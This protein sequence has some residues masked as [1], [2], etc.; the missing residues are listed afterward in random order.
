MVQTSIIKKVDLRNKTWD[1]AHKYYGHRVYF[2]DGSKGEISCCTEMNPEWLR[3]GQEFTYT[4]KQ[5]QFE[6]LPL[7]TRYMP[8]PY[9]PEEVKEKSNNGW[10]G[11]Q[12]LEDNPEYWI[13]RQKC[14]SAQSCLDRATRL[15]E[16][17]KIDHKKLL[18]EAQNQL[19]WL[20]SQADIEHEPKSGNSQDREKSEEEFQEPKTLFEETQIEW[21]DLPVP[22]EIQEAITSCT[23][24][25]K[26]LKVHKNLTNEQ[27]SNQNIMRLYISQKSKIK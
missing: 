22:A 18:N 7:L 10:K 8:E 26:L 21:N 6:D 3:P 17:G 20:L 23:T 13:K 11:N 14:I 9:S 5:G 24:M 25:A 27:I 19:Q 12:R 16:A 4:T 1:R 15:V 2:M